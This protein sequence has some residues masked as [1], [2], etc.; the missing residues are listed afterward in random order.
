MNGNYVV[1]E[2]CVFNLIFGNGKSRNNQKINVA[3]LVCGDIFKRGMSG[4][5]QKTDVNTLAFS[6][7]CLAV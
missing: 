4:N 2:L 1:D 7:L 6:D 3:T 5:N